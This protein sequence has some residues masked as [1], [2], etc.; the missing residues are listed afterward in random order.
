MI[1]GDVPVEAKRMES[2]FADAATPTRA[3]T[4]DAVVKLVQAGI[5]PVEAAWEELGYT[6]ERIRRLKEMAENDQLSQLVRSVGA[7]RNARTQP[8]V[9]AV[10]DGG[11]AVPGLEGIT[12]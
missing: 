7:D 3:Q 9:P 1:D 4:A 6:T 8:G 11:G 10:P 12:A 2:I 5:L